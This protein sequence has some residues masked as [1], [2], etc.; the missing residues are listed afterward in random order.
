MNIIR[1][2]QPFIKTINDL[3]HNIQRFMNKYYKVKNII[4]SHIERLQFKLI[5]IIALNK[6]NKLLKKYLT[7]CRFH[8]IVAKFSNKASLQ[9][10]IKNKNLI[11]F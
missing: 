11:I 8:Y 5:Y 7:V 4:S 2:N 3:S 10:K 6:I 1:S 9:K